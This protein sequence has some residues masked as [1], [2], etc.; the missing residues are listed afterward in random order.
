[1]YTVT[2]GGWYQRTTLHLSEIHGFLA[3]G[4]SRL[5]LSSSR[6]KNAHASLNLRTVSREF[7]YLEYILAETNDGIVI[8]YYEDGLYVLQ[9]E[10]DDMILAQKKLQRYFED[11]F[12]PAISF[13]FSL[14]APTPKVLAHIKSVHPTVITI[15]NTQHKKYDVD[16]KLFGEVYGTVTSSDFTMYKTQSHILIVA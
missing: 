1:M 15:F 14:G 7:G 10:S 12:E 2:F 9:L 8:R 6:L 16:K 13:I 3:Y 4:H 5:K 11:V